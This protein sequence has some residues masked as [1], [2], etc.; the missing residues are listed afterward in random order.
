M[1]VETRF[2]AL[3]EAGDFAVTRHQ[4]VSKYV[5]YAHGMRTADNLS[6]SSDMKLAAEFPDVVVENYLATTGITFN[7]FLKN[8]EHIKRMLNDPAL[9][10]FRIWQG[11]A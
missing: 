10:A 2:H 9:S 3:N 7:E 4:D 6:S 8:P 11:R 1:T 5:E